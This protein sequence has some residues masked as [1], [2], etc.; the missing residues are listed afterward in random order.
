[1]TT[2]KNCGNHYEGRY[3]NVC[4][5]KADTPPFTFLTLLRIIASNLFDTD[6]G[7]WRNLKDL[8]LRPTATI[9]GYLDGKRGDYYDWIKYLL[10]SISIATVLTAYSSAYREMYVGATQTATDKE[11]ME[12]VYSALMEYFNIF[13]LPM[14]LIIALFSYWFF[15]KYNYTEHLVI[16]AFIIAQGNI[17]YVVLFA[18][19]LLAEKLV[20]RFPFFTEM[21]WL[22]MLLLGFYTMFIHVQLFE[23]NLFL[24]IIKAFFT[25]VLSYIVYLIVIIIAL[26]AII[27]T[28]GVQ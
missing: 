16:N 14:V 1:M 25:F 19:M 6:R 24:R 8:S 12:A 15:R 13:Y 5:Q 7:F 18:P 10:V 3:C 26:V 17:F 22:Y 21:L 2:C 11:A 4:G 9:Q 27:A 28:N 20:Y 23:G